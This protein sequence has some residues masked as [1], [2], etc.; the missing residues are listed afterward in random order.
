MPAFV[1]DY[2]GSK[3]VGS[4][5]GLMLTA[6]GCASAFGPLLIAHMRESSGSYRSGL[7]VISGIMALS[8]LLPIFVSPPKHKESSPQV[9]ALDLLPYSDDV[10]K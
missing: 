8:V 3:N 9:V 6:W 10:A 2:F 7:H 5:Y 1:A 4:I